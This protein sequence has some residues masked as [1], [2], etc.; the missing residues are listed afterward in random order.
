MAIYRRKLI[1][2]NTRRICARLRNRIELVL[3]WA[4]VREYRTGDNP[5]RW[6]GHLDKM[7]AARALEFL[8]LGA[9]RT[10]EVIGAV[11]E[12]IDM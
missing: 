9:V 6:R 4:A 1:G 10:S 7:L 11:W 8:I 12:E 3:D 5:A 2:K